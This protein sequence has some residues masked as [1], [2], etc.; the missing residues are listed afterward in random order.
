VFQYV[1]RFAGAFLLVALLFESIVRAE[2]HGGMHLA[3]YVH[4]SQCFNPD[5]PVAK[6]EADLV[7]MVELAH[8]AGFQ[9]LVPYISTTSGRTL[10]PSQINPHHEYGDW[11]AMACVMKAAR[12]IDMRVVPTIP[13][14]VSG[15][16]RPTG[17][18]ADHLD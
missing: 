9:T 6:R 18:L 8:K 17:I 15:H 11:D 5:D 12:A 2:S 10:Y 13:T 14:L 1:N 16:D 7:S 4:L 3:A